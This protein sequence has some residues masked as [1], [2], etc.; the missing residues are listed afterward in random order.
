MEALFIL[1]PSTA[2]KEAFKQEY[3]AEW[4]RECNLKLEAEMNRQLDAWGPLFWVA[5]MPEVL[6]LN[7]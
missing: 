2:A 4:F 7:V 6:D 3:I 1:Q 5:V